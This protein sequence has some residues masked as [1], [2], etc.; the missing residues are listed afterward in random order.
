[1]LSG[2]PTGLK[3]ILGAQLVLALLLLAF[4]W[5]QTSSL[6]F[7][8]TPAI[9]D[10]LALATPAALLIAG[11]LLS[12]SAARRGKAGSA[13]IYAIVPIPLAILL[14]MLTGVM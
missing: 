5:S 8:R 6:Q 4:G 14:A 10:I 9:I 7:G 3:I 1:M 11:A 12:A 2:L 13:R